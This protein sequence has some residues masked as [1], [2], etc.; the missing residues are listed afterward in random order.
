MNIS[1]V[2][3][4]DQMTRMRLDRPNDTPP[5][6]QPYSDCD[7]SLPES[8]SS[9][10]ITRLQRPGVFGVVRG[11]SCNIVRP[12]WSRQVSLRGSLQVNLAFK[13]K[14]NYRPK[15][16]CGLCR[17]S[18]QWPHPEESVAMDGEIQS[19]DVK[20]TRITTLN[21]DQKLP[22]KAVLKRVSQTV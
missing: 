15:E 18:K 9:E 6:H 19:L 13:D 3:T 11:L 5:V 7:G 4:R 8:S 2:S 21:D 17:I 10:P 1:H 20:L 12:S 14:K 22:W 16:W